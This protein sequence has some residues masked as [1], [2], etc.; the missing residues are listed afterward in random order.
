M[1][2][3][4]TFSVLLGATVAAAA[5]LGSEL[6][7]RGHLLPLLSGGNRT[8]VH[9]V[10]GLLWAGW[11]MPLIL[12]FCLHNDYGEGL[13]TV[14]CSLGMA[15]A[16]GAA[17]NEIVLR[18]GHVGLAALALGL[19]ISQEHLGLSFWSYLFPTAELPWAGAFSVFA[20]A[21]WLF[22]AAFPF[23]LIGRAA[24]GKGEG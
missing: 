12:W 5:A 11:F 20:I 1:I 23:V 15:I 3:G 14:L 24:R 22:A 9:L 10:T 2:F 6:G 17:L 8:T 18:T 7:W 4:L 21:L 16:L 13:P 19:F